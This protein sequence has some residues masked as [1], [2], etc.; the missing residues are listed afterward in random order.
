MI[1][2]CH[3]CDCGADAGGR[4]ARMKGLMRPT[5]EPPPNASAA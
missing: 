3:E 5:L 2:S 4:A 1:L